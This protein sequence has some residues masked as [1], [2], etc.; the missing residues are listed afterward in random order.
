MTNFS[1]FGWGKA[2]TAVP[3]IV[4]VVVILGFHGLQVNVGDPL[5]HSAPDISWDDQA[6][7]KAMVRGQKSAV[8]H[9]CNENVLGGIQLQFI[10]RRK[11]FHNPYGV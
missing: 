3:V 8:V 1:Y 9:V 2:S 11:I 5:D 10:T 4:E 7:G 6:H